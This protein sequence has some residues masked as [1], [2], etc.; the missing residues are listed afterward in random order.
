MYDA[1]YSELPSD[2][3]LDDPAWNEDLI[4]MMQRAAVDLKLQ[5]RMV[6][7]PNALKGKINLPAMWRA[8]PDPVIDPAKWLPAEFPGGAR[9]PRSWTV[10]AQP[11]PG[12]RQPPR[13]R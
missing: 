4:R 11:L 6:L 5:K 1:G 12:Q 8:N 10:P 2:N 3:P 7:R 13:N 9:L